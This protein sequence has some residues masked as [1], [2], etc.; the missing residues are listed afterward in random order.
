[1]ENI[2]YLV[3]KHGLNHS[4][5]AR[6][7]GV[8]PSTISN[9][10]SGHSKARKESLDLLIG[11]CEQYDREHHKSN[12]D[13]KFRDSVDIAL[14]E[15]RETLH[16]RTKLSN[17]NDV[18]E[19]ICK[20]LLCQTLS[21]KHDKFDLCS[22]STLKDN[23]G[24]A[25]ELNNKCENIVERYLPKTILKELSKDDFHLKLKNTED[26]LAI[27]LL[28]AISLINWSD[29]QKVID[30]DF[31]N[32]VFGKF[33][34]DNFSQEK[35]LGQY[36]TPIE[37]I[38]FMVDV[39][40]ETIPVNQMELLLDPE[41]C[42]EFGYI[43]D[44]SC[45]V[46]SFL[47]EFVKALSP[48]VKA[49]YGEDGLKTWLDNMSDNV[50]F[51]IDK[52]ER[53]VKL[54]VSNFCLSGLECK[55]IHNINSLSLYENKEILRDKLEG[56][57]GL[58]LTNPPF[59][60]EFKG[61]DICG[62]KLVETWAEKKP[63][64]VDSE[65][66]FI[67]RYL[68][69]LKPNGMCVT[70]LPDSV[71]FNKRLFQDLRN[72]IKEKINLKS[73]VSFPVKTFAISGT[74][75]KTSAVQF[76]KSEIKSDKT[77]F[78]ICDELGFDVITKSTHRVRV[79]CGVNE[80]PLIMN[81]FI[82]N[83]LFKNAGWK[84][85]NCSEYR[86]DAN[87]HSFLDDEVVHKINNPSD[88]DIK[89]VDIADIINS[90]C[91]ITKA[92]GDF[93]YIEISD[94]DSQSCN[95]RSKKVQCSEAPSRARKKVKKGDVLVSTVR[96]EQRKV[97]V[98]P[99][100]LDGA[101]CTTGLVVLRPKD[102]NPLT[103]SELMKSDLVAKQLLRNNVGVSYPSVEDSVFEGIILPANINDLLEINEL[104]SDVSVLIEQL[105][106]KQCEL[107]EM[108]SRAI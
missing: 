78:A 103:L 29:I 12:Q 35:Q 67:E 105:R 16:R 45:G 70:V 6:A 65:I 56:N 85:F 8:E 27:E 15:I 87:F 107:K 42:S 76:I 14:N 59:G 20:L 25:F 32:E 73:V 74:S 37:M 97:G 7:I 57:V 28:N 30:V 48:R 61:G 1:M 69:W 104:A 24:V 19:E 10:L 71:L 38:R 66:L 52:S 11:L 88:D 83:G 47:I 75:A 82:G 54:A 5:I 51:A 108:V 93:D 58:I 62:Y 9:W 89:L 17:R 84:E 36:L 91:N 49:L 90:R 102:I 41:K 33:L 64:K 53:M 21:L 55:N 101:I 80:I 50:L 22:I 100:Y 79:S 40:I 72:G 3:D 106:K 44:P 39:S 92:N 46:G 98:V 18:L 2:K 81:C 23:E 13:T 34:S 4:L 26:T 96:P 86:W 43:L 99:D 68:D 94:I 77:F 31:L 95:V 63:S 60:A